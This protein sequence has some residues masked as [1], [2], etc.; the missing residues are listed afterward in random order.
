MEGSHSV[1]V[2]TG[3][4]DVYGRGTR[5]MKTGTGGGELGVR[6]ELGFRVCLE[7]LYPV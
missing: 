5:G 6:S 3:R 1:L 4:T 2:E 7:N